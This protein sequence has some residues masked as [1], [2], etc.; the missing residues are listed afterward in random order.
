MVFNHKKFNWC[1]STNAYEIEFEKV[2]WGIVLLPKIYSIV[3]VPELPIQC[4][5]KWNNS[6]HCAL[7]N[8]FMLIDEHDVAKQIIQVSP[9]SDKIRTEWYKELF[10]EKGLFSR[11]PFLKQIEVKKWKMK[12]DFEF[13]PMWNLRIIY[14]QDKDI[15]GCVLLGCWLFFASDKTPILVNKQFWTKDNLKTISGY[16]LCARPNTNIE[17]KL[18]TLINK[19]PVLEYNPF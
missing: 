7:S 6:V 16:T 10:C 11:N 17:N 18:H 8:F 19:N 4:E 1:V 2:H 13:I 14:L 9:A 5:I 15:Y 12:D 3:T